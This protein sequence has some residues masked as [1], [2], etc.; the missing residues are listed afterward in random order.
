MKSG[1]IFTDNRWLTLPDQQVALYNLFDCV[2]TARLVAPTQDLLKQSKNETFFGAEFQPMLPV[3]L[4]MQARGIGYLDKPARNSMRHHLRKEIAALEASIL[5]GTKGPYTDKLF[6]SP[7]QLASLLFEEWGLPQPKATRKRKSTSTD[8][9][10]LTWILGHLRKRDEPYRTK[11]HDLFHRSRLQTILERYLV[12]EG[13][14]DGRVRPT[15]KLSGTETGRFAYAGGPGEAVQQWPAECRHLIRAAPGH[16]FVG[17]DYSQLEARI[18]ATLAQDIPTLEA[19]RSGKDIHTENC[20]TLFGLSETQYDQ[21][22]PYRKSAFRNY[23]K[24][25]LYGLSYGAKADSV[26]MKLFCPCHRCAEKA[27]AQVNLSVLEIK[28]AAARWEQEHWAIMDWRAKLVESVYGYGRDRTWVSPFGWR[29]RFWEPQDEG[30]R[31]LMNC[32]M[33][34]SASQIVNRAMRELHE[35]WGVPLVLQMHDEL[36]AEV[37]E[38]EAERVSELMRVVMERPVPELGNTVFPTSGHWGPTWADLK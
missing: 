22:D 31:S 35:V 17:R 34:H 6:N 11:L 5:E 10:A 20:R 28:R 8:L 23:A 24:T 2:T 9:H 25:F 29:R 37:P 16:T 21:L 1:Q 3:V 12:V 4:A 14:P 38:G 15:I 36:I 30:E 18:L 19:L 26:K 27:P 32:P 13:D 7:K 33:Q